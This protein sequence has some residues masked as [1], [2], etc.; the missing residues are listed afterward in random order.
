MQPEGTADAMNVL[1]WYPSEG[2]A[3]G[4]AATLVE[5]GI[6]ADVEPES[7]D[8]AGEGIDGQVTHEGGRYGVTVMADDDLRAR[9]ILGLP[10]AST[11]PGDR[12]DEVDGSV[13]SVLIPVLVAIAVLVTVPL[14]AFFI[15]F[16]LS[17][18]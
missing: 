2:E 13:R 12:Q 8:L 7:I 10:D 15:T 16:K 3:R 6:G 4:A 14:L 11:V 1:A 17:G 18:G 9:Q 5:R